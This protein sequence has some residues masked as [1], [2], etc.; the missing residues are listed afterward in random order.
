MKTG[1]EYWKGLYVSAG[2]PLTWNVKILH[3]TADITKEATPLSETVETNG[4]RRTHEQRW[5]P[6]RETWNIIICI[7][8]D[9]VRRQEG[10]IRPNVTEHENLDKKR[11]YILIDQLV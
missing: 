7:R 1:H 9:S 8:L 6:V 4:R 3:L 10:W 2:G 11:V 5:K